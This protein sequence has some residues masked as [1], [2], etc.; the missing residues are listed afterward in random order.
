M[1][2]RYLF[3][4][5]SERVPPL[6]FVGCGCATLTRKESYSYFGNASFAA[7]EIIPARRRI[8]FLDLDIRLLESQKE[9]VFAG[10]L[11]WEEGYT[12]MLDYIRYK[13]SRSLVFTR[14][15]AFEFLC[16]ISIALVWATLASARVAYTYSGKDSSASWHK[17]V[18]AKRLQHNTVEPGQLLAAH[19]FFKLPHLAHEQLARGQQR[20]QA[21]T[22]VGFE[23]DGPIGTGLH[24][25]RYEM[26]VLAIGLGRRGLRQAFIGPA[27]RRAERR[28]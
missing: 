20:T 14:A 17:R 3:K 21:L 28:S 5:L 8:L 26:G 24:R 15:T 27:L 9:P 22:V 6:H 10:P 19:A 23:M 11:L 7:D 4:D 2:R 1:E 25:Q 13:S 12:S 18:S 16:L